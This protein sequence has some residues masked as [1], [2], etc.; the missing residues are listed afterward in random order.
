MISDREWQKHL[1]AIAQSGGRSKS[2]A[3][4]Q[5]ARVNLR[6]AFQKRHPG[7]PIPASL[8]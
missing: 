5:A 2:D 3:K 8:R 4:K 1:A 7:K 6:K